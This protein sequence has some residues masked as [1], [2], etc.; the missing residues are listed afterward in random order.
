MG[1]GA[2]YEE[3]AVTPSS[4]TLPSASG[5]MDEGDEREEEVEVEMEGREREEEV[6]EQ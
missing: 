1:R 4:S 6:E 3:R 5:P 2:C